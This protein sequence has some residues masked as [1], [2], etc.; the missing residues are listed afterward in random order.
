VADDLA[1]KGSNTMTD[2][3]SHKIMIRLDN[4]VHDQMRTLSDESGVP[5]ASIARRIIEER[6]TKKRD[7][8]L[9]AVFFDDSEK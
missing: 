1:Q 7:F 5:L 4:A 6:L 3:K 8:V 2:S 9:D